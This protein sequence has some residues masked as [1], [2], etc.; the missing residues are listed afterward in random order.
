[1]AQFFFFVP[2]MVTF[3]CSPRRAVGEHRG[4]AGKLHG[5]RVCRKAALGQGVNRGLVETSTIQVHP[6]LWH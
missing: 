5:T 6:A 4:D 2:Q 3:I 1:M